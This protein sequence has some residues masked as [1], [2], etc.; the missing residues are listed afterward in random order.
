MPLTDRDTSYTF[1]EPDRITIFRGPLERMCG[2]VE[3]LVAEIRITVVH[4]VAHY[5]GI[6]DDRLHAWGY[7]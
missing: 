7:G 4:E 5:F 2:S 6:D 3:E 1:R